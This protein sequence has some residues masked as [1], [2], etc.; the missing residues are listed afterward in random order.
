M[1]MKAHS[2][3]SVVAVLVAS[4]VAAQAAW[5]ATDEDRK[6]DLILTHGEIYTPGG[7]ARALAVRQGVILALGEPAAVERLRGEHTRVIDL[8]GATV[9]PGLHDMHVHPLYAGLD[10]MK[11]NFAQGAGP[12]E[13]ESALRKC[14]AR[15]ARGEWITGGRWDAT[16]LGK[17]RPDR[18]FLDRVAPDN[19][20]VLTD[21]SGHSSWANSAALK[22]AGITAATANP[23]GGFIERDAKGEP[24][25]F[26]RESAAGLVGRI[27]PS[28]TAAQNEKAL[29]SSLHLMLSFGITSLTDAIVDADGLRAY[30]ALA[31]RGALKQRVKGCM[32]W[33]PASADA[34]HDALP[35]YI[36]DRNL[37]ARERFSPTCIKIFLD[38]VP[39]D[40][41]T[42]AMVEPYA[43]AKGLDS[44]RA[45]GVLMVQP[46]VL[47][48][49]TT[50]FDRMGLTVKYHAA[51]DAAV[52]EGLD[53]I[54]AARKANGYSGLMHEVGHD[55]FVQEIDI[56]TSPRHRGH[57]RDVT[58]YLVSQPDHSGYR[59]GHWACAHEALDSGEG[60][61]RLRRTRGAGVRL[62]GGAERG[63]LDRDRNPGDASAARGRRRASGRRR[64]H[65]PRAGVRPVYRECRSR[66]GQCQPHR[67]HREGHAGRRA[68]ARPESVQDPHHSGAR[69]PGEDGPDQRRSRLRHA[70]VGCRGR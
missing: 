30:A 37:F 40:S 15:K 57:F 20:V 4:V 21:I 55:S 11:C 22:L 13:I 69:D 26:L 61:H 24:N 27:V 66:D 7:W 63:P 62:A 9:V 48:A 39:T 16:S 36:M 1:S 53:A 67:T 12:G 17:S 14:V 6:A 3:W 42:A 60:C 59:Q 46:E 41:H 18:R 49:A 38:G 54:E 34:A 35:E 29:Q 5:G 2:G 68:G 52:R 19:P 45:R 64:T 10:A 58:L 51:G 56:S 33:R 47:K 28:A 43:D 65:H 50:R 23:A 44:E 8:A 25:G 70:I 31:D 32:P